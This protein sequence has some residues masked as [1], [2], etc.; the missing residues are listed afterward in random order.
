MT[1]AWRRIVAA[2]ALFASAWASAEGGAKVLRTDYHEYRIN[3]LQVQQALGAIRAPAGQLFVVV[4]FSARNI[5]DTPRAIFVGILHT[6][7][8]GQKQ[9]FTETVAVEGF[10]D[11]PFFEL[12]PGNTQRMRHAYVVP[13]DLANKAKLA[14]EPGRARGATL[15]LR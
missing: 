14:W 13:A 2:L 10:S 15:P 3:G 4:D 5:A 8:A 7:L 9:T 1:S 6:Q 11:P 12:R